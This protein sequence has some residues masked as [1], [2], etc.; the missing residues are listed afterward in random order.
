MT[1]RIRFCPCKHSKHRW[2]LIEKVCGQCW[3]AKEATCSWAGANH[4][5]GHVIWPWLE[6]LRIHYCWDGYKNNP[7]IFTGNLMRIWGV[8]EHMVCDIKIWLCIPHIQ[9]SII[10][11]ST[12]AA[13]IPVSSALKLKLNFKSWQFGGKLTFKCNFHKLNPNDSI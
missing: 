1:R 10:D 6:T 3:G 4:G 8:H 12:G 9:Y 2:L 13:A 7:L 11:L 5:P